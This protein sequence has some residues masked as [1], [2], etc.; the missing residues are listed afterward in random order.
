MVDES[1]FTQSDEWFLPTEATRG[2]WDA[3]ACHAGPPTGLLA[4][5]SE[6]AVPEQQ[7]ARLTVELNRPVP[8]AGFRIETEVKRSGRS[9]SVTE[10][11]I[12]D[13][14]GRVCGIGRGLHIVAT[15]HHE[16]PT[17]PSPPVD[18][19]RAVALPF[20]LKAPNH[21][22]PAFSGPGVEVAYSPGS[23]DHGGPTKMWMRTIPLLADEPMSPFQRVCPLADSGNATSRNAEPGEYSFVNVDLTISLHRPP[24]GEWI[25]S[26]AV[27]Y[28]EPNGIGVS[29]AQLLDRYGPVGRALQ[30]LLIRL[31]H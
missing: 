12:V 1:F 13:E 11:T 7:L 31:V 15:G 3:D 14:A 4:R 19:D 26:D 17:V 27:S 29:D 21:G 18:L 30:T 9:V 6:Q 2:P 22:L 5:A 24:V 10:S 8:M 20:P 23:D 28:W 25:G 16:T